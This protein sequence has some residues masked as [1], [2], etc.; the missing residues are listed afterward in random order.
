MA[1]KNPK[2]R[3]FRVSPASKA[4]ILLENDKVSIIGD[5]R[6]FMVADERGITLK[7]PLSIVADSMNIRRGGLFV[8]IN[9]FL[10]MI[11]STIVTPIPQK[12]PYPPVFMA[13]NIAM[14]VAFFM[15]LLV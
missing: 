8:G 12:I 11:P 7:G 2:T 10:E 6:H 4:S 5:S 15:A 14:D 3:V 13:A 9:D 1:S